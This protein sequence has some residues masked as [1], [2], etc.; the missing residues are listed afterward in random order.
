MGLLASSSA[1]AAAI[2]SSVTGCV[3]PKPAVAPRTCVQRSRNARTRA[4]APPSVRARIVWLASP[5][6]IIATARVYQLAANR[7]RSRFAAALR[8]ATD[9][10]SAKHATGVPADGFASA[11]EPFGIGH[12]IEC[13]LCGDREQPLHRWADCAWIGR[14]DLGRLA[15][16][17]L[18]VRT[19]STRM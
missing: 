5:Y 7:G 18:E 14:H 17:L 15:G 13:A 11:Y 4:K 1:R 10:E 12:L 19:V 9:I 2:C 8:R 16:V 6:T 3:A